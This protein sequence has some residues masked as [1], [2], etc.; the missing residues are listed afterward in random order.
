[1]GLKDP[2]SGGMRMHH[3]GE[4]DIRG[5]YT[6]VAVAALCNILTEEF[7]AGIGEYVEQRPK[8][9]ERGR[10]QRENRERTEREQRENRERT[11]REQREN[12]E[13]TEREQRET[14]RE[15]LRENRDS[16]A[17]IA[18]AAAAAAAAPSV[19]A[20]ASTDMFLPHIDASSQ[21]HRFVPDV[22]GGVRGG[23]GER[24]ARGVHV[25]WPRRARPD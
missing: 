11:E 14:L 19:A 10:E 15:T 3:D 9:R 8:N 18:T 2:A 20:A 4:V 23:A 7:K 6:A 22:R 24:G 16:A 1:M 13:R 21:V 5:T 12:R 17:I 25:L